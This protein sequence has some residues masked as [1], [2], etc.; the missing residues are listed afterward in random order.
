[1]SVVVNVSN[2]TLRDKIVARQG[3]QTDTAFAHLLGIS[4]PEWHNVR[5]G[6]RK[7]LSSL[8]L[9]GVM[10]AFPDLTVDILDYLKHYLDKRP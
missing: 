10:T 3:E 2:S 8:L 7:E 5:T 4:R 1:M 9:N 6:K